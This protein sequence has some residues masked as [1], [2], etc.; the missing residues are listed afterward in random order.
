MRF[1]QLRYFLE[2][3]RTQ[4]ISRTARHLHVSQPS[5][6]RSIKELE[7]ELHVQLFT[8]NGNALKLS[9]IGNIFQ[10]D[11]QQAVDIIDSSVNRIQQISSDKNRQITFRFETSSPMIPGIVH[12]IKEKLPEVTIQLIQHGLESNQLEH[13]D[14]EF[15]THPVKGNANQLLVKEEI[16]VAVS[17]AS[18]LAELSSV[19]VDQLR[20]QQFILTGSSPLRRTIDSFFM[21]NKVVLKPS[22]VTSD[23]ETLRGLIAE[24]FGVGLIPEYSWANPDLSHVKLLHIE[25]PKLF[26]N[27]Y[28]SYYPGIASDRYHKVIEKIIKGYFAELLIGKQQKKP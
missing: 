18:K 20:Q 14:F 9:Q 5:L 25:P 27:I 11:I 26:R 1:L 24:N 8:R 15:S 16:M 22:F 4:N 10:N 21:E 28:L 6:S 19:K 3:A 12:R 23:R 2:V 17:E 7:D 13:Y